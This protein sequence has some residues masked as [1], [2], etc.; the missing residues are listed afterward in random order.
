MMTKW[1][2]YGRGGIFAKLCSPAPS[3]TQGCLLSQ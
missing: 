1:G 2:G 3:E